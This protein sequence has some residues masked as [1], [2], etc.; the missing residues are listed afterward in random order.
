VWHINPNE[1]IPAFEDWNSD[2]SKE[3]ADKVFGELM[4][5]KPEVAKE[6]IRLMLGK[7]A[8][9]M[10][11]RQAHNAFVEFCNQRGPVIWDFPPQKATQ[12][13]KEMN[14]WETAANGQPKPKR[15]VLQRNVTR[16]RS[17]SSL[18]ALSFFFSRV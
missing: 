11:G 15:A 8:V 4:R 7:V 9:R 3:L 13:S 16:S 14:L 17:E 6:F 5:A 1:M 12:A 2:T 10:P 18:T